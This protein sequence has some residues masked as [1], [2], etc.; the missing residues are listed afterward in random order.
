M[1]RRRQPW[2]AA[3]APWWWLERSSLSSSYHQ[4]SI[5]DRACRHSHQHVVT[6]QKGT[7][8]MIHDAPWSFVFIVSLQ[9][10]PSDSTENSKFWC[11]SWCLIGVSLLRCRQLVAPCCIDLT[12]GV[13]AVP[14]RAK[15]DR[16]E[17]ASLT[18][19]PGSRKR[20]PNIAAAFMLGRGVNTHLERRLVG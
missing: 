6:R 13:A 10:P 8:V 9:S 17:R 5:W 15:A 4:G 20:R 2:R 16:P 11:S 18:T 7:T 14:K 12:P 3:A 19:P 1:R